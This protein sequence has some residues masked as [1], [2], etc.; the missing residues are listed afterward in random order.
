MMMMSRFWVLSR[1]FWLVS[2]WFQSDLDG[3]LVHLGLDLGVI[4]VG[5]GWYLDGY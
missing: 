3:F 4:L 1:W 5:T 2:R